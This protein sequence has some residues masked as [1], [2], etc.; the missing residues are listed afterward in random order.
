[1]KPILVVED[2]SVVTKIIKHVLT[3]SEVIVADYA[4]SFEEAR[5]LIAE[6]TYFAAIVDLNLPDAPNGEVVDFTRS[7]NI[8]TIVLTSSFD[9]ERRAN[10]LKKG[11]VDYVTKEGRYSYQ[12]ARNT[13]ERLIKNESI[14]VLVVDDSAMQRSLLS[15]LLKLQ[16]FQVLEAE[17]GIEAI[18]VI[19]KNPDLKLVITDYNMPN[20]DG[21][22]LIKNLRVKYGKSDLIIMG[23]S[24]EGQSSLSAKFIKYGANDF[25]NKPFNQEEFF[26]RVNHDIE[27]IELIEQVR[28]KANRD[29]L[30]GTYNKTYFYQNGESLFSQYSG[31]QLS[32]SVIEVEGLSAISENY[33]DDVGDFVLSR[34]GT[35]LEQA[36]SRFFIG[37]GDGDEFLVLL[38]G[39]N[40]EKAAEFV[41]RVRQVLGAE[42]IYVTDTDTVSIGYS[43]GVSS[44]EAESLEELMDESYACLVRAK[45]AGGGLVVGD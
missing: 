18:K 26:C 34:V 3:Q 39:L 28:D 29:Q 12:L 44:I 33:G 30:T 16:L 4:A 36:F 38:P 11:I 21:F 37:R 10:M 19:L 8:P 14:K 6:K 35:V 13:I 32:A 15:K 23:I 9:E 43:A 5:N 42:S 22:E 17:D 45:E 41:D 20:M 40:G 27:F 31:S 2:S 1:M 24:S 25:L 7:Q